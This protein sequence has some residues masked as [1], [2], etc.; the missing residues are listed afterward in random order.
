[1]AN[2]PATLMEE[3]HTAQTLLE[4]H[5]DE[6]DS[7]E[8]NRM[9]N[10]VIFTELLSDAMDKVVEHPD[11]CP[12]G[13]LNV[14]DAMDCILEPFI[15]NQSD[16]LHVETEKPTSDTTLLPTLR[17]E[18][19]SCIVKLTHLETILTD[20]LYKVPLTTASDLPVGEHFTRSRS[21]YTP[22]RTG[23][24]PRRVSTGMKYDETT[25]DTPTSN[26]PKSNTSAAK[27]NRSGPSAGRISS[28]NKSS[29]VPVLRLP[30]I[31]AEPPDVPDVNEAPTVG[32]NNN[33]TES[34]E[35]DIPLS[36]KKLRGTFKTKVH[37]LEKK[38]ET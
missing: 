27:P 34:Q 37:V 18:T 15:F 29:I 30:P 25:C 31:K 38:V 8:Q 9:E 36:A 14:P 17:V 22:V 4:L 32:D 11:T 23:R 3:F 6:L 12:I 1:M 35:D 5:G 2:P 19:K 20:F 21:A 26:K 24:K 7:E 16:V 13:K 28:R 10:S 33:T